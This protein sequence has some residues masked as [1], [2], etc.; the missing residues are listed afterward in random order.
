MKEAAPLLRRLPVPTD[1]AL[2][3]YPVLTSLREGPGQL[4]GELNASNRPKYSNMEPTCVKWSRV[5]TTLIAMWI[6]VIMATA[7]PDSC[8]EATPFEF[9]HCETYPS[10]YP[11]EAT[12]C[13]SFITGGDSVDF[14]FGYF[15]FC[16]DLTVT[17]TLYNSLCDSITSNGTGSFDI[18]PGVL[19]VVCGSVACQTPGG[20]REVCTTE[21]LTLP[22]EFLGM[23]GYPFDGGVLLEWSTASEWNS[24]SFAIL[25]SPDL[26]E[27][28][29]LTEV[30]AA[31]NTFSKRVYRWTDTEPVEGLVYYRL[32]GID[33][34]GGRQM[35]MFLPVTWTR[36]G[37]SSL[38]PFDL[39]GRRVK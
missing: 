14:S 29:A 8:F 23:I 36:P 35:L 38:G 13:Y 19:Y 17:Y 4:S 9:Y 6:S 20:I 15:A 16:S 11:Q 2:G 25:R 12:L 18:A 32:D 27:W 34:D 24:R 7:Q 33:L 37:G 30:G 31:G 10:P 3:M 1:S 22:V 21:Q 26:V 28:S 39:L 5:A